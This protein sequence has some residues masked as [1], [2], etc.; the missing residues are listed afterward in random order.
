MLKKWNS[1]ISFNEKEIDSFFDELYNDFDIIPFYTFLEI[2]KRHCN[3][4][5]KKYYFK[6]NN[7]TNTKSMVD[8]F[9]SNFKENNWLNDYSKTIN[10]IIFNK[11]CYFTSID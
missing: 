2:R 5:D 7:K 4:K 11:H 8:E 6:N 10:S 1:E 3:K 9:I